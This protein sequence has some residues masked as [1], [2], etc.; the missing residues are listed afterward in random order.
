[1]NNHKEFSGKSCKRKQ[2]SETNNYTKSTNK[3][4]RMSQTGTFGII[5]RGLRR[6]PATNQDSKGEKNAVVK[7][8]RMKQIQ[9]IIQMN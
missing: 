8:I 2:C 7:P 4:Q 6:Q 9:I 5:Q 1:M 3:K